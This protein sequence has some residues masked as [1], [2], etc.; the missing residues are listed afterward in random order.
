MVKRI[1]KLNLNL[2]IEKLNLNLKEKLLN[3][4]PKII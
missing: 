4:A 3:F 2:R 1:E